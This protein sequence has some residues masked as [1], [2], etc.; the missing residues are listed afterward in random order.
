MRAAVYGGA[1]IAVVS[2]F[3]ATSRATSRIFSSSPPP[4]P[5]PPATA[6]STPAL[7]L[8]VAH[9]DEPLTWLWSLPPLP[10]PWS[11]L[12]VWLSEKTSA[13]L[14]SS[15]AALLP[16]GAGAGSAASVRAS[17]EPGGNW[18][19]EA[20]SYLRFIVESYEALP[21]VS[22]F[23]QGLPLASTPRLAALLR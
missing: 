8:V 10:P 4:P 17:L 3:V 2:V 5:A 22:A 9:Y 18:G 23:V 11:P 14:A 12:S 1:A 15:R 7:T 20:V 16:G 19:C 21:L 13:G 6:E